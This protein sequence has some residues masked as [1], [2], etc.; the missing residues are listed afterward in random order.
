MSNVGSK[1]EKLIS[2]G[3]SYNTLRGLS[4]SQINLLYNRLVEQTVDSTKVDELTTKVTNLRSQLAAAG[5][6]MKKLGLAKEELDDEDALG[7]DALQADTGQKMPHDADDSAPDGMDDDTDNDRKMV[8]MAE[9]EI[10]EKFESKAQ[11]KFFWAKCENTKSPKAKKKWC[12]WAK[13]FSDKTPDFKKLPE[14]KDTKE[15][16]EGLTKLVEKYIPESITKGK[17][18]SM[19]E[20][21]SAP[22]KPKEKERTTT[23]PNV[24][25]GKANPFTKPGPLPGPKAGGTQTA[26]TKPTTKPTTKP[27]TRPGKANPFTKPGPLPGPKAGKTPE[28]LSYN[29]FISQGFSLK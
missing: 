17:L 26:P 28:W 24:R 11:Q 23:K 1:I 10:S 25:P 18:M 3:F 4:E 7:A 2:D 27:S 16:E 20:Q 8:G 5:Q 9:G 21:A 14:K 6:D 19:I 29:T 22:A 15:I 13:E 12:K